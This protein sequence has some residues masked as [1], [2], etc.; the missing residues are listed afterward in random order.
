AT[1]PTE[2][3]RPHL[4]MHAISFARVRSPRALKSSVLSKVS[5]GPR[6]AAACFGVRGRRLRTCVIVQ[7]YRLRREPAASTPLL[8]G[9]NCLD[10]RA[11]DCPA[12]EEAEQM[13]CRPNVPGRI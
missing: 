12:M 7:V 4:L 11:T 9:P 10:F 13:T 2:H 5:T 6:K 1:S 8:N 3:P